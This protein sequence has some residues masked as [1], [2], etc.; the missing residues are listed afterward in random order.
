MS[1]VGDVGAI[2]ADEAR[3]GCLVA[4]VTGVATVPALGAPATVALGS[5]SVQVVLFCYCCALM[6]VRGCVE[7]G[8]ALGVGCVGWIASYGVAAMVARL[9]GRSGR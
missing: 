1:A 9:G 5:H 6:T 4:A 7:T 2:A 8:G 3:I